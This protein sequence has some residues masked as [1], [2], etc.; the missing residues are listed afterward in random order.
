M[1]FLF[2]SFFFPNL[3]SME[4]NLYVLDY[5]HVL[6]I[7]VLFSIFYFICLYF[8]YFYFGSLAWRISVIFYIIQ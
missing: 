3:I 1:L 5:L 8:L 4:T 2:A 7:T 6:I